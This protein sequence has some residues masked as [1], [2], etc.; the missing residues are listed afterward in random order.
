MPVDDILS[1]C[2]ENFKSY[3]TLG[4]LATITLEVVPVRS[5]APFSE[6][7]SLNIHP[8]RPAILPQSSQLCQNDGI[9]ERGSGKVAGGRSGD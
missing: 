1:H 5:Y 4:R 2:R 8:G 7:L 6:L 9:F 3:I